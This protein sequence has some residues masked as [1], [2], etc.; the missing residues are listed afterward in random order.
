MFQ[1]HNKFLLEK[2]KVQRVNTLDTKINSSELQIKCFHKILLGYQELNNLI[3]FFF[4]LFTS[5]SLETCHQSLFKNIPF[6]ILLLLNVKWIFQKK[7]NLM[8]WLVGAIYFTNS[9]LANFLLFQFLSLEHHEIVALPLL[10]FSK[11][12]NDVSFFASIDD[13]KNKNYQKQGCMLPDETFQNQIPWV[14]QWG[15]YGNSWLGM[16]ARV[17]ANGGIVCVLLCKT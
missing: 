16:L 6:F 7:K 2:V 15:G 3:F 14:I 10:M 9:F 11:L 13:S 4:F 12:Y 8:T 17:E 1:G 5:L